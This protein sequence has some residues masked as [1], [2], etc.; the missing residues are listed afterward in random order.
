[1]VALD[2]RLRFNNKTQSKRLGINSCL[3]NARKRSKRV[4]REYI[5][6]TVNKSRDRNCIR[7]LSRESREGSRKY[8]LPFHRSSSF[9]PFR[10]RIIERQFRENAKS[11]CR[12]CAK[13]NRFRR[14]IIFNANANAFAIYTSYNVAGVRARHLLAS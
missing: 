8:S 4:P 7:Y 12:R 11:P 14:R 6:Y 10:H 5:T 3:C 2:C 1:M 13:R 9:R